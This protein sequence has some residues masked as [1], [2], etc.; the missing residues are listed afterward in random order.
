ME[1]D[2]TL[3]FINEIWEEWYVEGL[4]AFIRIPNLSLLYDTE[5]Q[6]NGLIDRA[7][8]LVDDYARRLEI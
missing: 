2:T 8:E 3:K 4:K 1:R 5:F 6:T 7:I